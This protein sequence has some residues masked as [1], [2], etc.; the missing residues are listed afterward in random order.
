MK[1][2]KFNS[3]T[4]QYASYVQSWEENNQSYLPVHTFKKSLKCHNLLA[5]CMG[6]SLCAYVDASGWVR[7]GSSCLCTMRKKS[8]YCLLRKFYFCLL[9]ILLWYA[10]FVSTSR[11]AAVLWKILM[12]IDNRRIFF[13]FFF[14]G[15]K[16]G[17]NP[18]L[19]FLFQ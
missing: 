11:L 6:M 19:S 2:A 18:R 12:K 17:E 7:A 9:K 14:C 3:I 15:G 4:V 1:K 8:R 10:D 13:F 5:V 16:V